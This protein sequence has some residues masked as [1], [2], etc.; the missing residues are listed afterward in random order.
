MSGASDGEV[1]GFRS[2]RDFDLS[3]SGASELDMDMETGNFKCEMSGASRLNGDIKAAG[4]K[5]V[6]SGASKIEVEGSGGNIELEASG[7]CKAT[8]EKFTVNDADIELS[9]ASTAKMDVTGK[10]D[11]I[12]SGAS[13]LEYSGNPAIGNI[14]VSGGSRLEKVNR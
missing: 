9:G 11:I 8:M 2:S 7:A 13:T 6:M 10:L 5:I 14:D 1:A 12:L 4:S 3:I